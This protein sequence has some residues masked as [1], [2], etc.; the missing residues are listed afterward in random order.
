MVGRPFQ[1]GA[2][3]RRGLGSRASPREPT[4]R[5]LARA[6]RKSSIEALV[7]IRDTATDPKT[8]EPA[9]SIRLSAAKVLLEYA[10]GLPQPMPEETEV[11]PAEERAPCPVSVLPPAPRP[12]GGDGGAT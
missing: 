12:A 11:E 3:P 5:A 9:Y 4:A 10:D 6:H 8:G 2:D 7:T 1:R